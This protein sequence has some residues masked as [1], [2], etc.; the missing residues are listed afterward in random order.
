MATARATSH[1]R[2][3]AGTWT[4]RLSNPDARAA[5]SSMREEWRA[6]QETASADALD[7]WRHERSWRDIAIESVHRGDP[8]I[9]TLPNVRFNGMVEA[10]GPDL[11]AVRTV[12]G[13]VDV[14]V[15]D[16]VLVVLQIG[17]RMK[18]GGA[19]EAVGEGDFRSALLAREQSGEVTLGSPVL[20]EP[21]YGRLVVGADHVC[22]IGRGGAE[23][24]FPFWSVSY[25]MPHQD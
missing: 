6:E 21:L 8:V 16:G 4:Q 22:L 15:C 12:S 17:E 24:Y 19:R 18:E 1:N 23:T 9:V 14:H 7:A 10:V 2:T 20:A 5:A 13:R 25:V 11:L 3:M